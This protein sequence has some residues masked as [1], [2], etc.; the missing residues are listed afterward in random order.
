MNKPTN[1]IHDPRSGYGYLIFAV[2]FAGRW[3]AYFDDHGFR[4]TYRLGFHNCT[5]TGI[6]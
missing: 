2:P 4:L 5:R 1:R 3:F 6:Y